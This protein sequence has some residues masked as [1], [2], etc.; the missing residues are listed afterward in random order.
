MKEYKCKA[1]RIYLSRLSWNNN[2][3]ED[4]TSEVVDAIFTIRKGFDGRPTLKL[5]N[6]PTGYEE[7]HINNLL[8]KYPYKQDFKLY[9]CA[10]TR[11]RW[12]AFYVEGPEMNKLLDEV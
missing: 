10:G 7:F 4:A 6:G 8:S 1:T 5:E 11:S 9:W 2:T 3:D 12:D